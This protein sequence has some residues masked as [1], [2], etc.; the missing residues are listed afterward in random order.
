MKIAK[1]LL[2][3]LTIL[4]FCSSAYA[5]CILAPPRVTSFSDGATEKT[6]LA[7]NLPA[8]L[9]FRF[10][11]NA[12]NISGAFTIGGVEIDSAPL[13]LVF[14]IDT[15]SSCGSGTSK[16]WQQICPSGGETPLEDI[17]TSL[18]ALASVTDVSYQVLA[19]T[20]WGGTGY[21]N[22]STQTY[23]FLEWNTDTANGI[24]NGTLVGLQLDSTYMDDSRESWGI[25][26]NLAIKKLENIGWWRAG[27]NK[28]V[29][30]IADNDPTGGHDKDYYVN[31]SCV[32]NPTCEDCADCAKCYCGVGSDWKSYRC[33]EMSM[34]NDWEDKYVVG[35]PDRWIPVDRGTVGPNP[36]NTM[37]CETGVVEAL[38]TEANL[39]TLSR[40]NGIKLVAMYPEDSLEYGVLGT[41]YTNKN[42]GDPNKNDLIELMELTASR[43][44]GSITAF[45]KTNLVDKITGILTDS[46]GQI[47]LEARGETQRN[48]VVQTPQV[49]TINLTTEIANALEQQL[50]TSNTASMMLNAPFG[51]IDT[52]TVGDIC[53]DY[54]LGVA[55]VDAI[56]LTDNQIPE[57]TVGELDGSTSTAP[58]A[59]PITNYEWSCISVT[60]PPGWENNSGATLDSVSYTAGA[61]GE[62]YLFQLTVYNMTSSDATTAYVTVTGVGSGNQTPTATLSASDTSINRGENIDFTGTGEDLDGTITEIKWECISPTGGCPSFLD[63][64]TTP[65]EEITELLTKTF[66]TDGTYEIRF[67]V[68][69]NDNQWSAVATK[70]ITVSDGG[71]PGPWALKIESIT[72]TNVAQE[73]G[74]TEVVL[75]IN[76]AATGENFKFQIEKLVDGSGLLGMPSADSWTINQSTETGIYRFGLDGSVDA[77]VDFVAG[78][79]KVCAELVSEGDRRCAVFSVYN[80]R[81]SASPVS[82]PENEVIIALIV[83][84]GAM[85]VLSRKRKI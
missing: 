49:N 60:C 74:T 80:V 70:T 14:V 63:P 16:C 67:S 22:C 21:Y 32:D 45:G 64:L 85:L 33:G 76:S 53:F 3:S 73:G 43:T 23:D 69:D 13:D 31:V 50:Q 83:L 62:G 28:I 18:E 35:L 47:E 56:I 81:G 55:P 68:K 19:M 61:E 29:V 20:R 51:N 75:Q 34:T 38:I 71:G 79:Y 44:G 72:A 48:K 5:E 52:L 4:L 42:Y 65:G 41:D 57:Y 25:S 84:T 36:T 54:S 12:Q 9:K 1:I 78:N 27:A 11:Q 15:S 77:E 66:N 30:F 58:L 6:F 40:F 8:E 2:V 59:D 82:V 39:V 10:E 7:A 26:T 24:D 37:E 17:K 46:M